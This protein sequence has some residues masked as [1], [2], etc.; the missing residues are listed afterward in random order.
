MD[1]SI[2]PEGKRRDAHILFIEPEDAEEVDKIA[3][4]ETHGLEVGQLGVLKAQAAQAADFFAYLGHIGREV[5]DALGAGVAA[6]EAVLHLGAR[7]L[8]QD[9]LHHG[10][11]VQVGVEQAGDD[12]GERL[13]A[14]PERLGG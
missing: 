11:L 6:L 13:R 10:E 8:V 9:H 3:F 7:K 4:D 12:H 2:S 5:A 1:T 14:A